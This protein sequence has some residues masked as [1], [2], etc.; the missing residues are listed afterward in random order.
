MNYW[1]L[2]Q[3]LEA[4]IDKNNPAVYAATE[5]MRVAASRTLSARERSNEMKR[6]ID[7]PLPLLHLAHYLGCGAA[8]AIKRHCRFFL[9]K[10]GNCLCLRCGW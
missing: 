10:R 5:D 1:N 3:K 2:L 7:T 4:S 6:A 9:G 8:A